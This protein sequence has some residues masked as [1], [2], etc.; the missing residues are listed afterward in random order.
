MRWYA[1]IAVRGQCCRVVY[2][3]CKILGVTHTATPAKENDGTK[4]P[5]PP[6]QLAAF[7]G[8]SLRRG[9]KISSQDFVLRYSET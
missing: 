8:P 6:K 5:Q 1:N 4:T 3:L 7:K 9:E 2:V